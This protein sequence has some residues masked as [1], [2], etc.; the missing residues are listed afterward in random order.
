MYPH[1]WGYKPVRFKEDSDPAVLYG[2]R[3][4]SPDNLCLES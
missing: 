4:L 3:S 2:R 1:G